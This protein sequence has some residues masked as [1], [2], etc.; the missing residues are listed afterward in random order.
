MA[1]T[2]HYGF[3][4]WM[5]GRPDEAQYLCPLGVYSRREMMAT[6][7]HDLCEEA[8]NTS[9][10]DT[11]AQAVCLVSYGQSK[12]IVRL[13]G[14]RKQA[15]LRASLLGNHFALLSGKCFL[16]QVS[17][18]SISLNLRVFLQLS[19]NVTRSTR[20]LYMRVL[21]VSYRIYTQRKCGAR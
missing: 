20:K 1:L 16:I 4:F 9:A 11:A 3:G 18:R 7:S 5:A 6:N 14:S 13:T 21:T 12:K 8:G 17:V 2:L 15:D 10:L 19:C